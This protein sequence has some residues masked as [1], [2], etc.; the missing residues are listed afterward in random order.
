MGDCVAKSRPV[1]EIAAIVVGLLMGFE[2]GGCARVPFFTRVVHEDARVS[3][4]L[5][6]EVKGVPYAHPVK[7]TDADLTKILA[8][9]SIRKHKSLPLALLTEDE[10]PA[11]LFRKDERDNLAPHLAAGLQKAGPQERV[12]FEIYAPAGPDPRFDRDVTAG[13]LAVREPFF[14]LTIELFHKR[15]RVPAGGEDPYYL[16]GT[17]PSPLPSP[18]SYDLYFEPVRFWVTDPQSGSQALDFH[19]F[20]KALETSPE[21]QPAPASPQFR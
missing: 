21:K 6:Q 8:M 2:A 4:K 13:W 3:V 1:K 9:F 20:L 18:E 7:V 14:Y 15:I 11:Q 17:Y 19:N 10:P 12:H 5:Q 16:S